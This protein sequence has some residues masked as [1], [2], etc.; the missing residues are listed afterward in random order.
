MSRELKL[1]PD[2]PSHWRPGQ[3]LDLK[4]FTDG[5]CRATLLGQD[6]DPQSRQ[7]KAEWEAENA[8]Q[9]ASMPEAQEFVSRWYSPA[10]RH[11]LDQ[12]VAK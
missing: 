9:F 5:T 4:K 8:V 1:L 7:P 6:W 11:K 12:L 3:L 10:I 2:F